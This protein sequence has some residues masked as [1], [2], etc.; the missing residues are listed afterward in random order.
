[1]TDATI[2]GSTPHRD[3][4]TR[5]IY[6]QLALIS[7]FINGFGATQALLRDEQGTSR[8]AASLHAIAFA[9]AGTASAIL[10]PWA[11]GRYGR[12]R[13]IRLAVIL[14]CIG[15]LTFTFPAG[16]PVTVAGIAIT[17]AAV[18]ALMIGYSA[19]LLDY[20]RAAGPAALTEANA[21]AA[22]SGFLAPLAIGLGA[23]TFLGWRAG[24]WVTVVAMAVSELVRSRMKDVFGA[25]RPAKDAR[26]PIRGLPRAMWWS[27]LLLGTLVCVEVTLLQWTA[28]LLRERAGFG[29]ASAAA[30]VA[31]VLGGIVLGRVLG[32]RLVERFAIDRLLQGSIVFALLAFSIAWL[33]TSAQIIVLGLFLTGVGISLNWPL[34]VSR[35]VIASGG[36]TDRATGLCV[37]FAGLGGGI[38]PFTLGAL[39]DQVGV[40]WAFM[41]V[42]M[43]LIAAFVLL[44]AVPVRPTADSLATR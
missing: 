37:V 44:R 22:M 20:Q 9:V 39:S 3:P 31:S 38:G 32:R 15:V 17:A 10:V 13:V 4:A 40:H 41:I 35:S 19:F 16:L 2:A 27:V 33:A 43:L 6:V 14:F 21:F 18:S 36:F 7:L 28:D 1:M 11:V 8:T 25:A 24:L 34:G 26:E 12:S 29:P 5:L 30:A 42:P 23:A